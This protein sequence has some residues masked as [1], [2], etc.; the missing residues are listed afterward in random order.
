VVSSAEDGRPAG[1]APQVWGRVPPRNINFTGREEVLT[2]LRESI[3]SSVTVVVPY[4]L[5]GQAGVGKTQT[6]I[7]YAHRYR[8]DYELVW[9]IS[10][11]QASLVRSTL[12]GLAPHLGVPPT[13]G[14]DDTANAVLDRL[15]R[16]DPFS[17]WLLIFDNADQPEDLNEIIPQG[18][19]GH[20]LITSRNHRWTSVV[21]SVPVDVFAREESVQFLNKRVPHAITPEYSDKLAEALGDL[22]LALEQAGAL[23]TETGMPAEQYLQ[24]LT[25]RTSQLLSEG[26]PTEYP[27]SMTAAWGLSVAKLNEQLPEAVELLRCCA[28]FGPEPIP[29]EMFA[30]APEGLSAELAGLIRDPIRLSRTFG[31]LGR[32]A[33]ARINVQGRTIQVH[34]LIQALVREEVSEADRNRLR[35]DVHVLLKAIT[36][37]APDDPANWDRYAELLTHIEPSGL[38]ENTDREMR[39]LALDF[40]RYLYMSGDYRSAESFATSFEEK[41]GANG[42]GEHPDVLDAQSHR[43][44]ATREL[45][46]YAEAYDLNRATMERMEKIQ[47]SDPEYRVSWLRLVTSIGAD[48]RAAGDFRA[49]RRHDENSVRLHEDAFGPNDPRTLQAMNN[50]ALDLGLVS[51]YEAARATHEASYLRMSGLVG[52]ISAASFLNSWSGL[53]RAVRL[54]GTFKEACDSG[55]EAYAYG[56]EELGVEHPWTLRTAKDLSIA[57]RRAGVY[58]RSLDIAVEAHSRYLRVRGL[59]HPDALASSM[60]LANIMRTTGETEEALK[61]AS[62][63]L[64]R[65]PEVYGTDHPYYHGCAGNVALLLRVNGDPRSARELNEKALSGLEKQLGRDH[66]YSLTVAT[67]LASDLAAL[68]DLK[69]ATELGRG[70]LRRLRALL[71][72]DHPMTL[73]CAANLSADMLSDGLDKEGTELREDTLDRYARG[74]GQNHPD[75][76]VALEGRHLDCD[77]DPPPI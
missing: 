12:A 4:A 52:T 66:H 37:K 36:P 48:L 74:M 18:G 55:E 24:L 33:L 28:F 73:A 68:G 9:W 65:Y 10:A 50:L 54:C 71:G 38:V 75:A 26:K 16:G 67:N 72:E 7:E 14:V 44:I 56:V 25:E 45:G 59:G 30:Q 32:Y 49:A 31:E 20:V 2:R 23:Q 41:W 34:R 21:G 53:V 3:A 64:D 43:G 35:H 29:R 39:R 5:H 6:A 47:E 13:T 22:P 69:S 19:P 57:Q 27:L 62:E 63:A 11:D 58:D 15:R 1:R 46:R 40:V 51:E 42:Q 17:N 60:C 76:L 8:G 77:F 70:T 61:L